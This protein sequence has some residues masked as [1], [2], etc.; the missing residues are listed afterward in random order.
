VATVDRHEEICDQF[1]VHAEEEFRKGDLLQAA[2]KGWGAVA[3]CVN[4]IAIRQGWRVGTHRRL[5]ENVKRI[6]GKDGG[7]AERRR[8]LFSS[9]ESLHANFYGDFL[10]EED[11][12]ERLDHAAELLAA[13][14]ER[15]NQL[16]RRIS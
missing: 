11:V 8:L 14:K 1:L 16:P 3:H 13:L 7:L 6:I 12:R 5:V 2:E 4:A 10:S 15:A 9:V